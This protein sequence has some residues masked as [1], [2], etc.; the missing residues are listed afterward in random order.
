M[1]NC[2]Y[3]LLLLLG[4]MIVHGQTT[5]E[6]GLILVGQPSI[7]W[8]NGEWQTYKEGRWIRY[9]PPQAAVSEQTVLA[10]NRL[11]PVPGPEETTPPGEQEQSFTPYY[12]STFGPSPW[13]Y[14]V[15][16]GN[17]YGVG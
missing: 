13:V 16:G 10:Q 14:A 9:V 12:E 3:F 8:R 5:N 17:G 4:T 6:Q 7:Y 11:Y 1:K 2:F 15:P